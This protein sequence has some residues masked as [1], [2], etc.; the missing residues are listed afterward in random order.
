MNP[1]TNLMNKFTDPKQIA[2]NMLI[3]NS[4]NQQLNNLMKMI[5]NNDTQGIKDMAEQVAQKN[6]MTFDEAINKTKSMFNM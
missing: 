2:M 1:L 3:N 4:G 6:G 5:N